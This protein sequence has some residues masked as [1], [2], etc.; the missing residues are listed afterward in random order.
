MFYTFT[1]GN[2]NKII[3][4]NWQQLWEELRPSFEQAF[5]AVFLQSANEVFSRVPEEDIFLD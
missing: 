5:G 1:G 4:D 2:T 3:N